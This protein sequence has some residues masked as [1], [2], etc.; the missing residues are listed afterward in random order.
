[1]PPLVM[2]T[3]VPLRIQS[4]PSFSGRGLETAHVRSRV[5]LGDGE[6]AQLDVLGGAITLRK[7]LQDL[8]R[9]AAG[10]DAGGRQARA[11]DRE[12][13]AGV[14]PEELLLG[15]WSEQTAG[16]IA[17]E[18]L[19]QEVDGVQTDVGSFLDQRPRG[20]LTLVPLSG[21]RPDPLLGEVVDPLLH[22]QLLGA[23]FKAD[24]RSSRVCRMSN[25]V[26]VQS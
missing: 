8:V 20:L 4:S 9:G 1:M 24:H 15:D 25:E 7:P 26:T 10:K 21:G 11:H 6:G 22:L 23:Q 16:V 3:L 5:G 17:G 19:L 13:D 12:P 14:A 2:K 18:A